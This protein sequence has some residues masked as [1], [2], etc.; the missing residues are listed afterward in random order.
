MRDKHHNH[1]C[2]FELCKIHDVSEDWLPKY[3]IS[4]RTKHLL[5]RG[6]RLAKAEVKPCNMGRVGVTDPLKR[7]KMGHARD[8]EVMRAVLTLPW[9]RA[10]KQLSHEL[11]LHEQHLLC[12]NINLLPVMHGISPLMPNH[13]ARHESE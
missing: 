3:C 5:Q 9:P 4:W 10:C 13:T 2:Y 12:P 1:A 8:I 11:V 6:F 7:K